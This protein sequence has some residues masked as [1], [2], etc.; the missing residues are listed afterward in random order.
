MINCGDLVV[1]QVGI[2]FVEANSL[3][4]DGLIVLMQWNAAEINGSGV[5]EAACFHFECVVA[6]N[7]ILVDPSADGKTAQEGRLYLL[8]P[9]ATVGEIRRTK[10]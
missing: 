9:G 5:L 8:R 6:T 7:S 2:H 10:T 1:Q 4:D 3:F